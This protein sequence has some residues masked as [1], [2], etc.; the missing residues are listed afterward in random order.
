MYHSTAILLADGSVLVSGSNPNKDV[1]TV[2]WGTSYV[3]QHPTHT[4][5][6]P[7]QL[8]LRRCR[9]EPYLH[10]YQLVIQPGQHQGRR[11]PHWFLDALR[12]WKPKPTQALPPRLVLRDAD[13]TDR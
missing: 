13:T 1:T 2:Q 6:L 3:V 7:R 11:H 9:V 8:E 4:V 12:E 5:R 10:A